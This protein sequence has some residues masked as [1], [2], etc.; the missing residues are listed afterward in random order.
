[1]L[2]TQGVRLIRVFRGRYNKWVGVVK[3]SDQPYQS[4]VPVLLAIARVLKPRS[5][6]ELGMGDYSTTLFLDRN[7]FPTVERLSSFEDDEEWFAKIEQKFRDDTRFEPHLVP[8]PM[9]KTALKLPAKQ[10]DLIFID[11]S[12]EIGRMKTILAL[13]LTKGITRG[14]VTLVH[15]VELP[16]LRLATLAFPKRKY[17]RGLSPQTGALCWAGREGDEDPALGDFRP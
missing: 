11:D 7:L 1:V 2:K 9:W 5:V 15:D 12:D 14:P 8:S 17:F 3:R 13:R 6:A 10:F 16:L 4:H